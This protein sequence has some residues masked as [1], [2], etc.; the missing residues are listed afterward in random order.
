MLALR[1][2]SLLP[3]S[4]GLPCH[5]SLLAFTQRVVEARDGVHM[6]GALRPSAVQP[7][8]LHDLKHLLAVWRDRLPKKCDALDTWDA[9]LTWRYHVF[10]VV[11]QLAQVRSRALAHPDARFCIPP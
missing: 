2:W 3:A 6:A 4:P 1:Q 9:L 10:G 8:S 7:P 5:D 11:T